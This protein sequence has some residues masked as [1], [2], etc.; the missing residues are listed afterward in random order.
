M[1]EKKNS[2]VDI[3]DMRDREKITMIWLAIII[4]ILISFI[5][6]CVN[7]IAKRA[8]K[9]MEEIMKKKK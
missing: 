7:A 2:R 1:I 4:Y 3:E 5:L 9:K 8:D 6:I